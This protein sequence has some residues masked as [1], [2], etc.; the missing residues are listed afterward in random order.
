MSTGRVGSDLANFL[1]QHGYQ[2]TLLLGEQASYRT[3]PSGPSLETFTTTEDLRGRLRSLRTSEP[4]GV[5]HVAAVSDFSF[6]KIFQQGPNQQLLEVS[7]GKISS[8]LGPLLAELLPTPKI[9]S[10]LR[11]WFPQGYLV[12]WKYEVEGDRSIA[13]ERSRQQIRETQTDACVANGP[14]YGPGFALLTF[15]GESVHLQGMSDLFQALELQFRK[16]QGV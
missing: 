15:S 3:E 4:C 7:S 8:R 2:V 1:A 12:G 11:G 14:G 9:L 13:L 16:S 10:E 6:G 5:F